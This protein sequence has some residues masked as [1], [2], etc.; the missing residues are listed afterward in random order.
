[1][2]IEVTPEWVR[3]LIPST[4]FTRDK[5]N[6]RIIAD[7][8]EKLHLI[9]EELKQKREFLKGPEVPK[10]VEQPKLPKRIIY[11]SEVFKKGTAMKKEEVAD[12]LFSD[13]RPEYVKVVEGLY[14]IPPNTSQEKRDK[15]LQNA[16][17]E[18]TLTYS[19]DRETMKK[20]HI[21]LIALDNQMDQKPE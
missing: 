14:T 4:T 19:D 20:A 21:F 7:A 8:V 17:D 9:I 16:W 11:K 6:Y 3:S 18:I 5:E 2:D 13:D 12:L 1:M 10:T 15:L